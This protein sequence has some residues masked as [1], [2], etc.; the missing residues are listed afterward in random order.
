M[1]GLYIHIPFCRQACRYCDFYFTVS[2]RYMEE[3][4]DCIIAELELRRDAAGGAKM[5]TLY[6]G[7]GT[8]SLL[9]PGQ[10][11]K[12]LSAVYRWFNF[13]NAP[14]ITL[15]C[16]PDDLDRDTLVLLHSRGVNRLSIGVQSFHE[17]DLKL[18][19]R[20]H[21]G[22]QALR[23]IP[24]AAE[25]GFENISIDLIYGIPD[26]TLQGWEINL[27]TAA[28]LPVNHISAYHL[29]FEAGTVFDHWRKKGRISPVT[30]EYSLQQFRKLDLLTTKYGF[31]HYEISNLA[32]QQR[33]SEHNLLYWSGKPYLGVGP[34]A[35]SFDGKRRSWNFSSLKKYMESIHT[36]DPFSESEQLTATDRYHDMLITA[37]RTRWGLDPLQIEKQCG[38]KYQR[39][40]GQ[41][42]APFLESGVMQLAGNNITIHPDHWFI[43]DHI[44]RA[45]LMAD[46]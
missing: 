13:R 14:E 28:S 10:L 5:D 21:S 42:A 24:E 4:V 45:L 25:A 20:S 34:S 27:E 41:K 11:D 12:I 29:T 32:R 18:L 26:Q 9:N 46:D 15:E 1:K 2:L 19:K 7:G 17:E 37:L 6:L 22:Q 40:F 44:L 30:E 8:P 35:H 33:Y 39:Y 16:N 36:H 31:E 43:S 23:C 38:K 3:L